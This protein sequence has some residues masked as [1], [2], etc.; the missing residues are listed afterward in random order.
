MLITVHSYKRD[1]DAK[2]NRKQF[3]KLFINFFVCIQAFSFQ[4]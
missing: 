1:N 3:V 2:D 4:Y